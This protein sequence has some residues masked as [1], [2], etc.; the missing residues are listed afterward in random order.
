MPQ[1]VK[2]GKFVFGWSVVSQDRRI[3]IPPAARQE[4]GF[5]PG[6]TIAFTCGSRRSGGFGAGRK[7]V[8]TASTHIS[9]RICAE[10]MLAENHILSLPPSLPVSPGDRLLVVRGSWLVLSFLKSGPIVDEALLHPREVEVPGF[11]RDPFPVKRKSPQAQKG[12]R[13]RMERPASAMSPR[14][15]RV[16]VA[17]SGTTSP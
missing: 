15:H 6:E 10:G 12:R 13:L 5:Q 2:R 7:Q 9:T 17:G 16:T 8:V 14:P 4:Y 3:A 1:L 11:G